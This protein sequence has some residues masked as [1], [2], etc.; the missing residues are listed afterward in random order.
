MH[1]TEQEAYRISPREIGVIEHELAANRI[2]RGYKGS[3]SLDAQE[4]YELA[5]EATE[6]A[7]HTLAEIRKRGS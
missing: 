1:A 7:E 5:E 3:M 6:A 2:Y 4:A